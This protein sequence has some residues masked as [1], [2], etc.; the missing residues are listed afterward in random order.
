MIP[1]DIKQL[2]FVCVGLLLFVQSCYIDDASVSPG[3]P[4]PYLTVA[5]LF[6]S[7]RT[8]LQQFNLDASKDNSVVTDRGA[9]L[10]LD[11][12]SF[13]DQG[14]NP[15][16][17]SIR[18]ELREVYEAPQIL[19]NDLTT[20]VDDELSESIGLI[21]LAA[22]KN[23]EPI[24]LNKRASMVLPNESFV[25]GQS[26]FAL[27]FG[28]P[29]GGSPSVDWVKAPNTND[30]V[31]FMSGE[32]YELRFDQLGWINPYREIDNT[33]TN[34]DLEA[35][36]VGFGTVLTDQMAFLIGKNAN[37]VSRFQR[38][39]DLFKLQQLPD[40][41]EGFIVIIAMTRNQLFLGTQEV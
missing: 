10:N 27:A 21:E 24:Q 8:N 32:G 29:V 37:T 19:L 22:F 3:L 41:F 9:V 34:Y 4:L 40:D 6:D 16:Q 18:L 14:G 12:S 23:N 20:A 39:G 28:N 2:L 31:E 33:G 7:T 13:T 5:E 1:T 36:A 38:N 30:Q 15:V 17:G 35:Q 11:A 26:D 25:Q